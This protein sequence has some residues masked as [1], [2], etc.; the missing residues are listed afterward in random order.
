M[1]VLLLALTALLG[2]A[3][4]SPQ[5]QWLSDV[6]LGQSLV[7]PQAPGPPGTAGD[8]NGYSYEDE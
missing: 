1:K 6:L 7:H 8:R 4:S 5:V 3:G 2:W